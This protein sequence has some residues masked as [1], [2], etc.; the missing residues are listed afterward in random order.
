LLDSPIALQAIWPA[1]AIQQWN[2]FWRDSN[3][4]GFINCLLPKYFLH[5]IYQILH[6]AITCTQINVSGVCNTEMS[7]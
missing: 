7:I 4:R 6:T 3:I 1:L 5:C 2:N